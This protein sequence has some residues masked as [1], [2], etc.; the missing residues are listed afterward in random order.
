MEQQEEAKSESQNESPRPW[1]KAILR[2][3]ALKAWVAQVSNLADDALVIADKLSFEDMSLTVRTVDPAHIAMIETTLLAKG[4]AGAREFGLDFG[5]VGAFLRTIYARDSDELDLDIKEDRLTLRAKNKVRTMGLVDAQ[6]LAKPNFPPV[7]SHLPALFKISVAELSDITRNAALISDHLAI[8]V[9]RAG[10]V[11]RAEGDVDNYE[12]TF[13][14]DELAILRLDDKDNLG[15]AV[16]QV[17]SLFPLDYF[18]SFVRSLKGAVEDVKIRLGQD[19]PMVITWD[20]LTE[21]RYALAPPV[22]QD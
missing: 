11:F 19:Y 15:V 20:G 9:N 10:V 12:A 7:E 16:E 8:T 4:H 18:D 1:V 6:G 21:G 13:P 5:K 22:E 14:P 3:K 17:R 2:T